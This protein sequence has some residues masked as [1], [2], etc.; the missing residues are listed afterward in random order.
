MFFF[1][2]ISGFIWS[3]LDYTLVNKVEELR[4]NA[5]SYLEFCLP[6]EICS[7]ACLE[8]SCNAE[9]IVLWQLQQASLKIASLH[10]PR[11]L[12]NFLSTMW[13]VIL[14]FKDLSRVHINPNCKK[15][16]YFWIHWAGRVWKMVLFP[17]TSS[18]NN[19]LVFT[20]GRLD[21]KDVKDVD[22]FPNHLSQKYFSVITAL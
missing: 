15:Y 19:F 18:Q 1:R 8:P 22:G 6:L 21:V 5:I 14:F 10:S 12:L 20:Q 2:S 7:F 3:F 4:W 11:L 17:Q 16:C 9:N 13:W